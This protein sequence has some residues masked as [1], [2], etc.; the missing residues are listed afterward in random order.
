MHLL[1]L[2]LGFVPSL[3]AAAAQCPALP[4]GPVDISHLFQESAPWMRVLFPPP[5]QQIPSCTDNLWTPLLG[6][7]YTL[8]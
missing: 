6:V 2:C 7:N 1:L 3:L 5:S 4:A 8:L